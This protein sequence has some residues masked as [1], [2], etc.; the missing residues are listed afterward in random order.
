MTP[1]I[2]PNLVAEALAAIDELETRS[3][4]HLEA[5]GRGG[6]VY[7]LA[8]FALDVRVVSVIRQLLGKH[9]HTA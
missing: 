5:A 4:S 3:D 9:G 1:T 7:T 2:S 8:D 6:T